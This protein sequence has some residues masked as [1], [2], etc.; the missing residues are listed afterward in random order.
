MQGL[1]VFTQPS[2][3][4]LPTRHR[5]QQGPPRAACMVTKIR[6][7][8]GGGRLRIRCVGLQRAASPGGHGCHAALGPASHIPAVRLCLW[9]P[10][11]Q[12][13]GLPIAECTLSRCQK[14][15]GECCAPAFQI[16]SHRVDLLDPCG[17]PSLGSTKQCTYWRR[18]GQ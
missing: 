4:P 12:H 10:W 18:P 11:E 8:S 3:I 1:L 14:L 16:R 6:M 2:R 5:S 15:D 17:Q 13:S 9:V 7:S